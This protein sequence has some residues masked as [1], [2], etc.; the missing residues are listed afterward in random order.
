LFTAHGVDLFKEHP[1]YE[2]V[3]ARGVH[4]CR[5]TELAWGRANHLQA[6]ITGKPA[7][8]LEISVE[9]KKSFTAGT[10]EVAANGGRG[11]ISRL[12]VAAIGQHLLR[13]LL[14]RN[15]RRESKA[16]ST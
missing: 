8:P 6:Q 9:L 1:N 5:K 10:G 16:K 4:G 14:G 15:V 12:R 7:T 13:P 11:D 2:T 3:V